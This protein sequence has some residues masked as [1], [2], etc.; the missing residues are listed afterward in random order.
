M[1]S[2]VP[3]FVKEGRLVDIDGKDIG[4]S[5]Y[6]SIFIS[7]KAKFEIL[8]EEIDI[9][10]IEELTNQDLLDADLNIDIEDIIDEFNTIIKALKQL[11][12]KIGDYKEEG[13]IFL[14]KYKCT[15]C[16]HK[17]NILR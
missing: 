9:Q 16:K 2:K 13:I 14:N 5:Y 6:T 12:K 3:F 10:S 17:F 8:S 1:I 15:N 4:S 11:D 7:K